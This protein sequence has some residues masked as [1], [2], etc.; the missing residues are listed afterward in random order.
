MSARFRRRAAACLIIIAS[1][2]ALRRWSLDLGAP[3]FAWKYGG[4]LLWGTM[5][6]FL[7][8]LFPK[9][10]AITRI[11]LIAS[12][13]AVVVELSRLHHTPWLDDFRRTTAG[14]LLLGRHF[15]LWNIVAYL[16]GI[17][18]GARIDALLCAETAKP[19][20]QP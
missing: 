7:V 17:G 10:G 11:A 2:L 13:I 14:A 3:F 8:A 1:G 6:Y 16:F 12:A 9:S 4:S 5:V 20:A 15:S 19:A 18:L